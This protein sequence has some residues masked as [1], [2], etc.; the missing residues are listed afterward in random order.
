MRLLVLLGWAWVLFGVVSSGKCLSFLTLSFAITV[1]ICFFFLDFR[2]FVFYRSPFPFPF[3]NRILK[4]DAVIRAHQFSFGF[5]C[6]FC[7]AG[8]NT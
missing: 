5:I 1:L 6:V 2:Y 3:H 8:E 7:H 4:C